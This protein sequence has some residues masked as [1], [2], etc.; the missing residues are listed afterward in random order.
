MD[1]LDIP[2]L[3]DTISCLIIQSTSLPILRPTS[4]PPEVVSPI[5]AIEARH[6]EG[7]IVDP[8]M[9]SPTYSSAA[10]FS[11]GLQTS[12]SRY[13]LGQTRSMESGYSI[14]DGKRHVGEAWLEVND[15]TT[16]LHKS[17]GKADSP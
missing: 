12:W 4:I 1:N 11:V 15:P 17:G 10:P 3:T 8:I 9:V 13:P 14:P 6:G 2:F 5:Q 16:V 7:Q